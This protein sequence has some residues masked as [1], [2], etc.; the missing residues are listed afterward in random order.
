MFPILII[1]KLLPVTRYVQSFVDIR[2]DIRRLDRICPRR[3]ANLPAE[4]LETNREVGELKGNSNV[5]RFHRFGATRGEK[6]L[7]SSRIHVGYGWFRGMFRNIEIDPIFGLRE[8]LFGTGNR[9][10]ACTGWIDSFSPARPVIPRL[11]PLRQLP[12]EI[13]DGPR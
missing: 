4:K 13:S 3:P 1:D 12:K 5:H 6:L 11:F 9:D 8:R 10:T 7:R 2:R